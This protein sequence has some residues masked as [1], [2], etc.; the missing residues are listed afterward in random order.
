MARTGSTWTTRGAD[1]CALRLRDRTGVAACLSLSEAGNKE[2][3]Y[4]NGLAANNQQLLCVRSAIY[5]HTI[6]V[7]SCRVYLGYIHILLDTGEWRGAC[8]LQA[9]VCMHACMF[10]SSTTIKKTKSPNKM[11]SPGFKIIVAFVLDI[12]FLVAYSPF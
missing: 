2:E 9:C 1:T 6:R 10:P 4:V 8:Q 3:R 5:T 11:H 12:C 7:W